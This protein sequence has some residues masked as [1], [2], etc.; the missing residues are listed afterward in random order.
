MNLRKLKGTIMM[1]I[2]GAAAL[3]AAGMLLLILVIIF[4]KG[5]ASLT[6]HFI[7]FT[8]INSGMGLGTGIANA[9]VGT[10]LLAITSTIL[11]IPFAIGTAIYLKKYAPD[12]HLTRFLRLMIEVLSGT[13][14]IVPG[15]IRRPRTGR[16]SQANY[17][18]RVPLCRNRGT[19]HPDTP[20]D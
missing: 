6:P 9:I 20:G 11:A 18:G 2:C 10:I 7:L 4:L 13:P 17:R 12:N 3:S 8:E 14:S 15:D 19:C 1:G 16:L 5:I